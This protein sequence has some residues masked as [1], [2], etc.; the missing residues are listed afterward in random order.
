MTVLVSTNSTRIFVEKA[1]LKSVAE[2]G[3]L[4]KHLESE[5]SFKPCDKSNDGV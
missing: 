2:S 1:F 4:Y 5:S 3:S